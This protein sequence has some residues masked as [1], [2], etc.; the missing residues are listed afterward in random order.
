MMHE[1]EQAGSDRVRTTRLRLFAQNINGGH[2]LWINSFRQFGW[3]GDNMNIGHNAN[4]MKLGAIQV[5]QP[6]T[7][8]VDL[9]LTGQPQVRHGSIGGGTLLT[10][11]SDIWQIHQHLCKA[12]SR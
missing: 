4:R 1:S 6:H 2:Q 5:Q 7:R 8:E 11:D 9:K 3:A 12:F 10:N